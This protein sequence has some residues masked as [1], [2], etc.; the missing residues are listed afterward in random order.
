[1]KDDPVP[2]LWVRAGEILAGRKTRKGVNLSVSSPGI[3]WPANLAPSGSKIIVHNHL[4]WI[5]KGLYLL[6]LGRVLTR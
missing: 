4:G 6:P 3:T 1:L 5:S 2:H